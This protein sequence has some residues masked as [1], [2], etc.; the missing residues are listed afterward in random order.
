[1]RFYSYV[2]LAFLA[3]GILILAL[4]AATDSVIAD[5]TLMPHMRPVVHD[6]Q[7]VY[8]EQC[9]PCWYVQ[10]NERLYIMWQFDNQY[11]LNEATARF[12]GKILPRNAIVI[13]GTIFWPKDTGLLAVFVSNA[14]DNHGS[15]A[16]VYADD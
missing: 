7:A 8:N 2:C 11:I 12:D 9:N 3:V 6:L 10:D 4:V 15:A 1:M 16:W 14:V 13:P 5:Q